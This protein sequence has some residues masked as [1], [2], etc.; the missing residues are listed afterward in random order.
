LHLKI[1]GFEKSTFYKDKEL[2]VYDADKNFQL[3]KFGEGLEY[4]SPECIEDLEY[5][6]AMDLWALGCVIFEMLTGE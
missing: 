3:P 2:N 1:K 4:I 6:P 5:S